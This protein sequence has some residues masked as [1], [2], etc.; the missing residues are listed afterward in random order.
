MWVYLI[1][2]KIDVIP[3]HLIYNQLVLF[4]WRK[5]RSFLILRK[6]VPEFL[7]FYF[8]MMYHITTTRINQ[9]AENT[10]F[11]TSRLFLGR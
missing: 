11:T 2:H 7:S 4:C 1:Y 6:H 10:R 9:K 3:K 5:K 8:L